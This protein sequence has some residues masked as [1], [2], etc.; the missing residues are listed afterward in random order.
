MESDAGESRVNELQI[1]NPWTHS[2]WIVSTPRS[3]STL[4][5]G[6]LNVGVGLPS[7]IAKGFN[8]PYVFGEHFHPISGSNAGG[9][10]LP[11]VSKCH[12]H[13]IDE[14]LVPRLPDLSTRILILN[15]RDHE[16][17]AWSLLTS[18]K[19]GTMHVYNEQALKEFQERAEQVPVTR[20][21]IKTHVGSIERWERMTR[22]TFSNHDHVREVWYEDLMA[23]PARV[24]AETYDWLEVT[25]GEYRPDQIRT[26]KLTQ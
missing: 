9:S 11:F 16:Q 1:D 19:L 6:L 24:I 18:G 25:G 15:R 3:G 10:D 4:L 2:A 17:Q 22:F 13:W 12:Y 5:A 21:E 14:A 26:H 20:A 8:S 7:S 23:D